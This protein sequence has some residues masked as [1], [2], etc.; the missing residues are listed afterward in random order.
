[1]LDRPRG[2]VR[3]AGAAGRVRDRPRR[4]IRPVRPLA[5]PTAYAGHGSCRWGVL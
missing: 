4:T 5:P 2:T 1:V 3:H